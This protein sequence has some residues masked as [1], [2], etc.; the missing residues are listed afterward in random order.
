MQVS[1]FRDRLRRDY[2]PYLLVH[3]AQVS[4]HE[5]LRGRLLVYRGSVDKRMPDLLSSKHMS[6]MKAESHEG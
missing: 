4:M 5:V 2:R 1:R 6:V 3:L